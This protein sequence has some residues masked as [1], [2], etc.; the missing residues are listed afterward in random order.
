MKKIRFKS[1]KGIAA[2]DGLI[3]IF[4]IV[5][6]AGLI[7]SLTY[8]IYLSNTSLK[9]MSTGLEYIVDVFEYVDQLYYDDVTQENIT[10]Y[11][12]NKYY[13]DEHHNVKSRA[14]VKMDTNISNIET[15]YKARIE[16]TKYSDITENVDL[17]LVEEIEMWVT[18]KLGNKTQTINMTT[19]KKREKLDTPNKPDISLINKQANQNIYAIKNDNST[20][21]TCSFTENNWYNYNA[22]NL[23]KVIVTSSEYAEG[24][25]ININTEN[26]YIWIPRYAYNQTNNEILYL[27]SNTNNYVEETDGVKALEDIPQGYIIPQ[28]FTI[29]Q[30][31]QVGIWTNDLTINAY[32]ILDANI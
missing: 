27:Y 30:E 6:F 16:I 23:P 31:K 10:D 15:P 20:W 2:S 9:R 7:A 26:V 25:T 22:G 12:N 13:Y 4:I 19:L 17:D 8:N 3:A 5:L 1:E 29:N 28:E 14:Q 24:T 32:Q 18:Y 21:K 11:F